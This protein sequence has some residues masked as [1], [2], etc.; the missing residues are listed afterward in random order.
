VNPVKNLLRAPHTAG[1]AKKREEA[2][3]LRAYE[4]MMAWHMFRKRYGHLLSP[5]DRTA[6]PK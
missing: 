6:T 5:V 4:A 2:L 3:A 1:Q